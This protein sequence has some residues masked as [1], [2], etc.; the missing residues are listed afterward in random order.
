MRILWV[1]LF[2]A[3]A[4]VAPCRAGTQEITEQD[5]RKALDGYVREHA[6]AGTQ[7]VDWKAARGIALPMPG[8]IVAVE[9]HP[10][11]DWSLRTTLRVRAETGPGK[12]ES[13]WVV[14]QLKFIRTVAVACRNLPIGHRIASG[15]L[16][17]EVREGTGRDGEYAEPEE[18]L[19][20]EIYRPVSQGACLKRMHVR[21]SRN[22]GSGDTVVIVAQKEGL[23]IQAPGRLLESGKIGDRV[24][25]LNVATGTEVYAT[26]VD[27]NTV[28]VS[29]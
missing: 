7:L 13:I 17:L 29:F 21:E 8:R 19:G 22:P 24:R 18:L 2:A 1:V 15:D 20:K 3:L 25:V 27:R 26:V 9:K 6:P 12:T 5:L 28:A 23:R 10:S 14:A 4:A 16:R 11:E